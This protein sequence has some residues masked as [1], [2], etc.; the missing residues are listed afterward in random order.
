ML[1]MSTRDFSVRRLSAGVFD[2]NK[3]LAFGAMRIGRGGTDL[4]T[5]FAHAGIPISLNFGYIGKAF[6]RVMLSIGTDIE[7]VAEETC[8]EALAD[9]V[10]LTKAEE[11]DVEMVDGRQQLERVQHEGGGLCSGARGGKGQW[12]GEPSGGCPRNRGHRLVV[13][14][15]R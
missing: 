2:V 3:R 8:F 15:R 10:A 12:V 4:H 13:D 7:A 9:E 6:N 14:A 1:F 5:V 11:V